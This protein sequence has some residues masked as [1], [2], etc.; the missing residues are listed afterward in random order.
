MESK[1]N[2]FEFETT[3]FRLVGLTVGRLTL[4]S[5]AFTLTP[6][7][8]LNKISYIDSY[9]Y[10]ST[11]TCVT[12]FSNVYRSLFYKNLHERLAHV[13]GPTNETSC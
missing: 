10:T 9:N 11:C 13:K 1:G 8:A 5:S 7:L 3:E 12:H 4:E 6:T 2:G